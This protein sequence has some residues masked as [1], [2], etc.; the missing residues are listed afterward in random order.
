MSGTVNIPAPAGEI[1]Q[2][3]APDAHPYEMDRTPPTARRAFAAV[4]VVADALAPDTRDD[5]TPIDWGATMAFRHHVWSCGLGVA[6]A[7]DTAQRGMGLSWPA[8]QELIARSLTEARSVGGSIVCGV[9]TDQ[10][11]LSNELTLTEITAAY[12]EQCEHVENGG[13]QVVLM[14]S[15]H[16][17]ATARSA[18][19]YLEVYSGVLSQ[20]G[21]PALIH[22]LGAP[23]D[24]RMAGYWGS[25]DVDIATETVLSLLNGHP[26]KIE[27]IKLSLL[28]QRLEIEL[29]ASLPS[30][31]RMFTGDDF[32][33]PTTIEGDGSHHSDALLGAFDGFAPTAAAALR[34]LDRGDLVDYHRIIDPTLS[35]SRHVFQA[36]TKF[37]KTGLVFL[38]FLNG[39]QDHFR[40]LG[41][42]ESARSTMHLAHVFVSAAEGGILHDVERAAWRARQVLS[43]FGVD[44]AALR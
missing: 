2:Y 19:D 39:L 20:L 18:D 37:Y 5:S 7:M 15:P 29:R 40:M 16:L 22:W 9:Q 13:G 10:L 30:G 36:P 31:V 14:A 43:V 27:G 24:E 12:V 23:F 17:A 44:Q 32:D 34:A 8:A 38:A 28:D 25:T 33:Y 4:H 21:R 1:V 11:S 35:F 42:F 3:T 41:G 26:A 6:E